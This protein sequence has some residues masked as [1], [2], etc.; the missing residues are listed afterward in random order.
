MSTESTRPA[1][2]PQD[3]EHARGFE[4]LARVPYGR[5]ATSM[6]ALPFLAAARH[7]VS[8]G[9]LL[10]RMHRGW[11][12]HRS[13]VGSVVAYGADNLGAERPGDD[14]QWSVQCVGT[15]E[16]VEPTPADLARFGPAPLHADGDVYDP[17]YLRVDP[18]F[19]TVH[20][21][22]GG[23]AQAPPPEEA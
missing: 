15:C 9:R 2:P 19:L 10:L 14:G 23:S 22:T 21:L 17:V 16:R 11:G 13:C 5:V 6:R 3:D 20:R 12:Y 4:L 7:V 1:T 18:H 8:D